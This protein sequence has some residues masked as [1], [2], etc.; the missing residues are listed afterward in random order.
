M[1]CS[2]LQDMLEVGVTNTQSTVPPL[3]VTQ[4]RSHFGAWVIVSSPLV[5]GMDLTDAST[6]DAVW[7]FL[8]NTHALAVSHDISA[9]S[10][11]P[12]PQVAGLLSESGSKVMYWNCGWWEDQCSL[13]SWQTWY[14]RVAN[15]TQV[16][17]LLMNHA[18][19]T[20][21]VALDPATIPGGWACPAGGCAY[22]DVWAQAPLGTFDSYAPLVPAHDTAFVVLSQRA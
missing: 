21:R 5:L 17:V 3:S 13:P 18:N 2:A 16:A 6:L 19:T 4:A 1:L 12:A 10:V 11:L 14:K 22:Y 20:Q 15:A 8:S 7:P 9:Y